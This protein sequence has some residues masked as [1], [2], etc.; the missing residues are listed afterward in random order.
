MRMRGAILLT[1][2]LLASMLDPGRTVAQDGA[3]YFPETGHWVTGN[4]LRTYDSV[5]DPLTVYGFPITD[6]FQ[7]ESVPEQPGLLVQYF[8][9][10]RFE[11][12]PENLPELEVVISPLGEYIY[13]EEGPGEIVPINPLLTQC[14]NITADGDPVCYAF[15]TFFDAYGGISQFGYP[16]SGLQYHGTRMV[17]YFQKARF[18]WHPEQPAGE[19][20]QLA[21]LG[22][23]YFD[24]KEPPILL[25]PNLEDYAANVLSLSAHAFV[26]QAVAAPDDSLG[27]YVVV[28]DQNLHPVQNA[29]VSVIIRFANGDEQRYLMELTNQYGFT[30]LPFDFQNAP[31]GIVEIEATISSNLLQT[32]TR[33]S[34]RVW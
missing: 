13:Q 15:L 27:L 1:L 14:R 23:E 19:R 4:F 33:S 8:E 12:H 6:A 24:L 31:P 32:K 28:Q 25:L 17:Q 3:R 26:D 20:V 34:F 18:E 29:Q 10:A 11:Y 16:I 30:T 7:T 9:K 5:A 22:R 2:V 21:D